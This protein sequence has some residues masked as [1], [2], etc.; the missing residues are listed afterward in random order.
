LTKFEEKCRQED[1]VKKSE[2][3]NKNFE[4]KFIEKV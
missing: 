4:N 3:E 1:F 2:T